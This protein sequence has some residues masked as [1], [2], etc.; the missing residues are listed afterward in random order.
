ML[1]LAPHR[2][3]T[4]RVYHRLD[5]RGEVAVGMGGDRPAAAPAP[6][7]APARVA[8]VVVAAPPSVRRSCGRARSALASAIAVHVVPAS[9]P[10]RTIPNGMA[11]APGLSRFRPA[12]RKETG[13]SNKNSEAECLPLRLRTASHRRDVPISSR[14]V[15]GRW[16]EVE[17]SGDDRASVLHRPPEGAATAA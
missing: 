14:P 15:V 5:L 11:A 10:A 2:R 12:D 3:G 1:V 4:E 17:A 7:P 16:P 8:M 9:S 13:S 6:A